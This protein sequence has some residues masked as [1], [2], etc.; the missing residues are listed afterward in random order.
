MG[1]SSQAAR[2]LRRPP[3]AAWGLLGLIA[4]A[5][6]LIVIALLVIPTVSRR[7]QDLAPLSTPE[8]VVEHFYDAVYRGNYMAAYGLLSEQTRRDIPLEGFEGY[9]SYHRQSEMRVD[10]VVVHD[11]TATVTI[12]VTQFDPGG[13]FG[14]NDW[15]FESKVLLAR[16][17]DSWRIIGLPG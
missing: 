10:A 17:G 11:S 14:G 12:T 2:L 6:V 5:V 8:G 1:L 4:G 16:E 13:I 9:V 15:S 7:P 3:R